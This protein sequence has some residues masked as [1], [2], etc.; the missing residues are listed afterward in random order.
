MP[1]VPVQD[2]GKLPRGCVRELLVQWT[3]GEPVECAQDHLKRCPV[4]GRL[5]KGRQ[6][7]DL[8]L[9]GPPA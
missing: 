4:Q 1:A 2:M 7:A 6:D 9:I 5:A 3:N 8:A